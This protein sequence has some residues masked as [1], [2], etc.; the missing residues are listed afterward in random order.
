[1]YS[2]NS[3]P[4]L[5]LLIA[6]IRLVYSL[7]PLFSSSNVASFL[8]RQSTNWNSMQAAKWGLSAVIWY[9]TIRRE[10]R[11]A[12]NTKLLYIFLMMMKI[13]KHFLRALHFFICSSTGCPKDFD[14]YFE[15]KRTGLQG[16]PISFAKELHQKMYQNHK[17][18]KIRESVFTLSLPSI[19][20]VF[21]QKISKF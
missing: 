13:C 7:Q 20:R 5:H 21:W 15:N 19:W 10:R 9:L 1:M 11:F 14:F 8:V 2:N 16:V 4:K 17:I 12:P 18:R 3:E 6:E